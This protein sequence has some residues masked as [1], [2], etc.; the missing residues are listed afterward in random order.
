M[1]ARKNVLYLPTLLDFVAELC[2]H[3]AN[4]GEKKLGPC[5]VYTLPACIRR[6][7][8]SRVCAVQY[9]SSD[10]G[11]PNPLLACRSPAYQVAGKAKRHSPGATAVLRS[12]ENH[13]KLPGPAAS[14]VCCH[15]VTYRCTLQ[16]VPQRGHKTWPQSSTRPHC[17]TSCHV[18]DCRS[19]FPLPR[20]YFGVSQ[21][22][23]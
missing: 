18:L 9:R 13:T 5:R 8:A 2:L 21:K 12:S 17:Q 22:N 10:G 7:G 6:F 20:L 16:P 14:T 4:T 19:P 1:G 11:R 23:C 15:A 3:E